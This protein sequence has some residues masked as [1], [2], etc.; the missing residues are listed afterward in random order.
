MYRDLEERKL[1]LLISRMLVPINNVRMLAE[2]LYEEP[3]VVAAGIQN[4]LTRRRKVKLADL[5]DEPWTLPPPGGAYGSLFIDAFG[6]VGLDLPR[7]GVVTY[8]NPARSALA[9]NGRFL[10]MV[11][12]SVLKFNVAYPTIKALPIDLPTTRRSIAIVTMK[13]RALSPTAKL[14]IE[15]AHEVAKTLAKRK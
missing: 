11:P 7:A 2:T 6:H 9:A 13:N 15:H 14:F 10:T 12:E 1:D 4:P 5:I 8:T 3:H